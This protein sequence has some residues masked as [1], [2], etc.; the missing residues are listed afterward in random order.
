M[1]YIASS[2]GTSPYLLPTEQIVAA[3]VDLR[4]RM[5]PFLFTLAFCT[6]TPLSFI[7][8]T[9]FSSLHPRLPVPRK[10]AH[11]NPLF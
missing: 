8:Y 9:L 4:D 6:V 10:G 5:I 7:A 3:Y 11:H 1:S 2:D